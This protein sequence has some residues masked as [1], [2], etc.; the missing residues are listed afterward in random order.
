MSISKEAY[1]AYVDILHEELR[2][3]MGCTEPIAVA[4]AGALARKTLGGLPDK[5]ELTVSGNIIK[6]VKSVIVP[7]T[8]VQQVRELV[9]QLA[10][11]ISAAVTITR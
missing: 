4:Y 9:Q 8:V 10:S 1:K 6:N 2:P 5:V 7:H 3:A 11:A